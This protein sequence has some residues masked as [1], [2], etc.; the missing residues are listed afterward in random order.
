MR[1]NRRGNKKIKAFQKMARFDKKLI[2]SLYISV[3]TLLALFLCVIAFFQIT[4]VIEH[5]KFLEEVNETL[6]QDASMSTSSNE[7]EQ[8]QEKEETDKRGNE[9]FF[10]R[11][12]ISGCC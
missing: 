3:G 2:K 9:Q 10:I 11:T 7:N 1:G 5:K 12:G 6:A 4:R 8:P